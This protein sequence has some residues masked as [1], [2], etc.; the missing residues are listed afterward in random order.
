MI[1]SQP[2]KYLENS[3]QT[4][5][6]AQLLVML[7][8]GAIRFCKLSIEDIR[9]NDITA[10]HN[11][12]FKVQDIISEFVITLDQSLPIAK[13]LLRLYDYLIYRLIQANTKKEIEPL[14]EV[15]GYLQEFKETWIQAAKIVNSQ[16]S[17]IQHG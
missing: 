15:L 9:K 14:E 16:R 17:G 11:H 5:S 1:Q 4:A 6:P 7:C 2:N 12:I 10:A 3:I 8:D 13:D